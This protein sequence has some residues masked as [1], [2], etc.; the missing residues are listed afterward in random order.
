[1]VGIVHCHVS[2]PGC[3]FPVCLWEARRE[4]KDFR[5]QGATHQ[6]VT[7]HLR[8]FLNFA[9]KFLGLFEII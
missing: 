1:M 5:L 7:G 4:Q 9:P 8:S 3:H 6:R 2:F